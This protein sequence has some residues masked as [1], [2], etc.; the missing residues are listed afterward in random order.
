MAAA[1][2]LF[3]INAASGGW[4]AD[5][6]SAMHWQP[7]GN[8]LAIVGAKR[9]VHIYDRYGA[10][11]DDVTL[12]SGGSIIS[13]GWD[14]DGEVL[15]VLQSGNSA[16]IV[17]DAA[18]RKTLAPVETNMKDL[19]WMQWSR[20]GPELAVGSGKGN[21]IIYNRRTT[22]MNPLLGKH[23]KKITCGAWNSSNQLA[24]GSEDKTVSLST[25]T[26]DLVTQDPTK[27]EPSEVSLPEG[28]GVGGSKKLSIVV[29]RKS[30]WIK[31]IEGD[32]QKPIDMSFNAKHGDIEMHR[33][34]DD[35]SLV[36]GF[37]GGFVMGVSASK[38]HPGKELF[39]SQMFKFAVTGMD[40]CLPK[41]RAALCGENFIKF[42]DLS[43]WTELVDEKI[44]APG[45]LREVQWTDDGNFL[46]AAL[47]DGRVLTYLMSMPVVHANAGPNI[48]YMKSLRE[49]LVRDVLDVNNKK[50]P[51]SIE[52]DIEPDLMAMGGPFVAMAK[53]NICW[54]YQC[55]KNATRPGQK[56]NEVDYNSSI[57][58][59]VMN[60]TTAAVLHGGKVNL[61]RIVGDPDGKYTRSFP[62]ETDESEITAVHLTDT[63]LIYGTSTGSIAYDLLEDETRA[64][65]FRCGLS[66]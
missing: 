43:S 4:G 17:W 24:L 1:Q 26:G 9:Q 8:Y 64:N 41:Q 10:I 52:V 48:A 27:G 65:E 11:V 66:V 40:L 7:D 55:D 56:V 31:A 35:A 60:A 21:L 46:S 25:A 38:N 19:C 59:V 39:G 34:C 15:A 6:K 37:S 32:V 61:H 30:L 45:I 3:E 23:S 62:D 29:S 36:V 2:V 12:T 54:F 14:K 20:A 22:R 51:L 44:V 33:W 57:D 13:I 5:C 49:V 50:T 58:R 28:A 53:N 47:S 18:E 63:F 42:V 16:I